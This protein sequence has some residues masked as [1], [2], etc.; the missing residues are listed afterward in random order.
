[1]N[2][3]LNK[4]EELYTNSLK[5]HGINSKA[6]G[7]PTKESQIIRFNK[8]IEVIEDKAS[9]VSINDLGCGYGAMYE[10]FTNNHFNLCQYNGYDISEAMLSKANELIGKNS[11]VKLIKSPNLETMANYTI[12]SG[13]FN[14][15]F[16]TAEDKW[17][18]F[19]KDTLIQMYKHSTKGFSFNLLTSYVDYKKD[20]LFYANPAYFFDFCK[21]N[22]SKKVSLLHDYDLWEWTI[23]V[24]KD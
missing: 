19:I 15:K 5:E 1:M 23:L 16:D 6:V 20:H 12:V 21:V 8:L 14:V 13:I 18:D 3:V 17:L 11:N 24:K 22:F 9:V 4:V 10:Y 2:N 7:W